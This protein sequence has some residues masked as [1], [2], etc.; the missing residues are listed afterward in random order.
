MVSNNST[1]GQDWNEVTSGIASGARAVGQSVGL[2]AE[3]VIPG[4]PAEVGEA[5]QHLSKLGSACER[6]ATG[7]H[8]LDTGDWT[9]PAAEQ[10]RANYLQ[11]AA[12]QWQTAADAFGE[13]GQALTQYAQV[14]AEQQQRATQAQAELEQ[15]KEQARSAAEA[16][17][18]QIDAGNPPAQLFQDPTAEK[19]AQAQHTIA[20]AK[21]TVAAAGDRAAATMRSAASRAP[22]QPGVIAKAAGWVSDFASRNVQAVGGMA[23]GFGQAVAGLGGLA[24]GGLKAEAYFGFGGALIDPEGAHEMTTSAA[25]TAAAAVSYSGLKTMVGVDTWKNHPTQALGEAVP[26]AAAYATGGGGAIA[27]ASKVAKATKAARAGERVAETGADS[28]QIAERVPHAPSPHDP[29][30]MPHEEPSPQLGPP[31]SEGAWSPM[32]DERPPSALGERDHHMPPAE[33]GL[34]DAANSD[35]GGSGGLSRM[36]P[37]VANYQNHL[38]NQPPEVLEKKLATHRVMD[39]SRM[40]PEDCRKHLAEQDAI[41]RELRWRGQGD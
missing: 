16:Y 10:F 18:A 4:N 30:H 24:L 37:D 19:R 6:V 38:M 27:A 1:L 34:P 33:Q 20:R 21:E 12:P 15:A 39:T 25:S 7:I 29:A 35:G 11:V 9:G 23:T 2:V 14:L 26:N 28:G 41:S 22:A 5:G 13:M 8:R 31:E 40:T 17:N 32:S 3:D 36:D